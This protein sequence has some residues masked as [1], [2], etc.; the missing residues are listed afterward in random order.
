MRRFK[1]LFV[2]CAILAAIAIPAA[3]A[4][5]D[6]GR[7]CYPAGDDMVCISGGSGGNPDGTAGGGATVLSGSV[8]FGDVYELTVHEA[9]AGGGIVG[10]PG[11]GTDYY[12]AGLLCVVSDGIETCFT[13]NGIPGPF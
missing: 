5:A 1:R 12:A 7:Y 2:G 10:G 4:F 11:G 13:G 9:L 6:G 3:P 8:S